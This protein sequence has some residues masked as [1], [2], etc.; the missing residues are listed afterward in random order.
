MAYIFR[1]DE[2][3]K[4]PPKD[5]HDRNEII[6]V[7]GL[8][9]SGQYRPPYYAEPALHLTGFTSSSA[10]VNS[11]IT[12]ES[13]TTDSVVNILTVDVVPEFTVENFSSAES[14]TKDSVINIINID[15]D[16][17]LPDLEFY[18]TT[19]QS[20]TDAVVNILNVDASF[21]PDVTV[22][23]RVHNKQNPEPILLMTGITSN[24]A[25]ISTL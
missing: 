2:V 24:S 11:L 7:R 8:Y 25:S 20:T 18:T 15:V 10:T 9:I 5:L 16:N 14:S 19:Q 6:P 22:S 23:A 12:T 4:K 3:Y 17:S 13:K 1:S 21:N